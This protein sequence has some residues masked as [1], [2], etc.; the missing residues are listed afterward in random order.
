MLIMRDF[1]G[2]VKG[3]VGGGAEVAEAA[4]PTA[5]VVE[6]FNPLEHCRRELR[7]RVPG[8]SIQELALHVG[9][10]RLGDPSPDLRRNP[11]QTRINALLCADAD[12]DSIVFRRQQRTLKTLQASDQFSVRCVRSA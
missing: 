8:R 1:G 3:L 11:P 12:A 6:P 4:V 9:P 7:P 10:E 2:G 5:R